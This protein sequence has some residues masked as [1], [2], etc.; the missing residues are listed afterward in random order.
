MVD[1]DR[2]AADH[3]HREQ[4]RRLVDA[5]PAASLHLWCEEQRAGDGAAAGRADI[6]V[7]DLPEMLAAHRYGPLP[8]MRAVRG[9]LP[10]LGVPAVDIHH[11]VSGPDLWLGQ[12]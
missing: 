9:D 4:L 6:G 11:D 10:R 12:K 3:G 8:F 7:P 5:C 2:G 1:A